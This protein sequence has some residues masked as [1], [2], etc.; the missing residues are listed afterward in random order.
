MPSYQTP[1]PLRHALS[2]DVECHY[3]I[4][5][6]DYLGYHMEPT[7]EVLRNTAW[8]L[9]LLGDHGVRATFFTLGNVARRYP[10]LIRRMVEEGHEL[11]VHGDQHLYIHDLTPS[12]FAQ[13]LRTAIDALEQAG[14]ARVRGHRA[15]AFSIGA[16]NLWALDVLRELGLDY[17]SSIFPFAGRRYGMADAPRTPWRLDNGLYEIPLTVIDAGGRT[18]PAAGGG[19]FRMFPYA[20]T[21]WALNQCQ[22][23]G[24]PAITYFH[25]HEFELSRPHVPARG[26]RQNPKGAAKLLRMNGMQSIGRGRAMR[27]KLERALREYAFCPMIELLPDAEQP[28]AQAS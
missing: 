26:W 28:Q 23:E 3:Q 17:D 19:Y 6:K 16:E 5:A 7:E 22:A 2:F 11:G 1:G 25:P 9:D 13:E 24:R 18:L 15:P 27:E 14:G 4:V 21:R 12:S 20:Y 8:L 10:R